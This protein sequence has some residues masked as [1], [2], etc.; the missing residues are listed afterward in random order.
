MCIQV[1]YGLNWVIGTTAADSV[2]SIGRREIRCIHDVKQLPRLLG[3]VSG[4]GFYPRI[5]SK[6]SVFYESRQ[7]SSASRQKCFAHLSV[8]QRFACRKHIRQPGRTTDIVCII[9]WQS[10]HVKPLFMQVSHPSFL[11]FKGPKPEGLKAPSLPDHF[12]KISDVEQQHAKSLLSQQSLFKAYEI[13]SAERNTK[14]Y[15]AMRHRKALG[16]QIITFAGNLLQ[17]GEPMVKGQLM[18]LQR[19][20]QEV[21]AV[22]ARG[23]PSC[24]LNYTPQDFETQETEEAKWI[25]GMDLMTQVLGSLRTDDS[26]WHGWVETEDYALFKEMLDTVREDFLDDLSENEEERAQWLSAWPFKD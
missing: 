13:L 20:W 24:P 10:A 3:I 21:F 7:L 5:E 18:Q 17:D 16:S 14:V 11:D 26:G 4:P 25:Q 23:Y 9:D 1:K 8:A 12:E 15:D 19:Q 22:Q 2:T 6:L